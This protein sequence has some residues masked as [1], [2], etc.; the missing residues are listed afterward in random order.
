ARRAHARGKRCHPRLRLEWI[1]GRDQPPG[2]VEAERFDGEQRDRPMR[3]VRGVE[4]AAEEPGQLHLRVIEA[5]GAE[6]RENRG[7]WSATRWPSPGI[8]VRVQRARR[9]ARARRRSA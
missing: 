8:R 5:L 9:G 4:T 2:L 3:A 7:A 6:I 1:A